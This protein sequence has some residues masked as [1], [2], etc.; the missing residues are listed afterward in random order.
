MLGLKSGVWLL[1]IMGELFVAPHLYQLCAA[2]MLEAFWFLQQTPAH[3][4]ALA[5]F[6]VI[7][8]MEIKVT[9]HVTNNMVT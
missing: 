1:G 8:T 5:E 7:M 2:L 3:S 6:I 9:H 4:P